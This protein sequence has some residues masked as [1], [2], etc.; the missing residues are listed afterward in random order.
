MPIL[1]VLVGLPASGKSTYL[2]FVNNPEFGDTVFVYSTDQL[3]EEWSAG[4][5]WSYNFGFSKYIG[6]AEKEMNSKLK[7]AI[8]ANV[9]VYWDQTNMS[10]KKRAKILSQFPDHYGR[11]CYCFVPPRDAAEWA[12]LNRRLANR[13]GKTI[14][15][16]IIESM[17]DSY[18]EP[19]LSEGFDEVRLYDIYGQQ[20]NL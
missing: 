17:S 2:E 5:G 20:I 12:E 14:P 19:T 8:E 15:R 1:T 9:D 6:K 11:V 7:L 3:V 10:A 4:Q 18:V 13:P 16:H